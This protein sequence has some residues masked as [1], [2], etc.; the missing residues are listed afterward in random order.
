M[1]LIEPRA[2]RF[3]TII[4]AFARHWI[5]SI[6]TAFILSLGWPGSLRVKTWAV[7]IEFLHT[8]CTQQAAKQQQQGSTLSSSMLQQTD[9][10]QNGFLQWEAEG[11][12]YRFDS[13][14]LPPKFKD[15]TLSK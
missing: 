13:T 12:V 4:S 14:I 6:Q 11:H 7:C 2:K 3:W 8:C 10:F 1:N 5:K 15:A 9:F